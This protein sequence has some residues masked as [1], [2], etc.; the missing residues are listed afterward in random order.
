MSSVTHQAAPMPQRARARAPL[1]LLVVASLALAAC[2]SQ[3]SV[4]PPAPGA[5]GTVSLSDLAQHPEVYADATVAAIGKVVRVAGAATPLYA[6]RGGHGAR[7]VLEPSASAA[8]YSGRDVRV[9]GIFTVSF[10][11]GYE[12]LVSAI[13]P[14]A[15]L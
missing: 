11:L 15:T 5:K 9:S 8:R 14:S 12:I 10:K 6:L 4:L 2:G 3:K 13:R 1:A 7:I